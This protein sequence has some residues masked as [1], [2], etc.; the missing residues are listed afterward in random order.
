[1]AKQKKLTKTAVKAMIKEDYTILYNPMPEDIK[2]LFPVVT[3][4][5]ASEYFGLHFTMNHNGKMSGMESIS[6]TC[7]VN[8]L[9]EDRIEKALR[10]SSPDFRL[11]TATKYDIKK[12]K[13]ALKDYIKK[14]PET[15]KVI[16]CGLCFSDSQQDY[17]TSMTDPLARNFEILNNGIIDESWLPIINALYFRIESFGDFASVNAVKNVLN[18]IRKNPAVRFGVW[19]KNPYFFHKVFN[20]KKESKPENMNFILSS[21]FINKATAIP[22]AFEYFVDFVFTVYTEKYAKAH[23][24]VINCGARSCLTCLKCYTVNGIKFINELLK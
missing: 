1:M 20:G 9:C 14:N 22:A 10:I 12:A 16:I 15:E 24:I 5:I 18:L 4:A 8:A 3:C 7:K 21:I 17:M 6:T 11:A 2:A 13:K 19:S 23:N